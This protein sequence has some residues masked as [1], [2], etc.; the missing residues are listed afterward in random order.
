MRNLFCLVGMHIKVDDDTIARMVESFIAQRK[1]TAFIC[2]TEADYKILNAERKRCGMKVD[3]YHIK[4]NEPIR[5]PYSHEL[6]REAGETFGGTVRYLS[7]AVPAPSHMPLIV[8]A[9]LH[10]F[11]MFHKAI[12]MVSDQR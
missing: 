9:Y 6:L 3:L 11:T 2:D 7:E 1:L 12:Y 8:R 10:N 5:G 4:H